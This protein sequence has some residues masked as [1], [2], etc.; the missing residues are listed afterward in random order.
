MPRALP[1]ALPRRILAA[2]LVPS[3]AVLLVLT[4]AAHAAART[5]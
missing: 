5:R 3:A 1:R 2:R 4:F